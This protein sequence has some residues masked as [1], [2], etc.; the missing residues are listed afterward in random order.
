[1]LSCALVTGPEF[2]TNAFVGRVDGAFLLSSAA[3]PPSPDAELRTLWQNAALKTT[4]TQESGSC[5]AGL[6]DRSVTALKVAG[7]LCVAGIAAYK[8]WEYPGSRK[9]SQSD[10]NA[11]TYQVEVDHRGGKPNGGGDHDDGWGG[12]ARNRPLQVHGGGSGAVSNENEVVDVGVSE[13]TEERGGDEVHPFISG[14]GTNGGHAERGAPV[15][16]GGI[17]KRA[18]GRRASTEGEI[19][20]N[21]KSQGKKGS[22]KRKTNAEINLTPSRA[23]RS[24]TGSLPPAKAFD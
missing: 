12:S 16:S 11:R 21:G 1:M 23:T 2:T 17:V 3:Q 19:T 24:S 18:S 10:T 14:T 22:R 8:I 5:V 9:D 20:G 4:V 13:H 7:A 15:D 6:S